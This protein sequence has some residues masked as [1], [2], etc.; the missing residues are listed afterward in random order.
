MITSFVYA[1]S[2]SI[3]LALL[4]G[5]IGTLVYPQWQFWPPPSTQSWQHTTFRRLF[6]VFVAGLVV[7]SVMA[8]SAT[9]SAWRFVIG[10]ALLIVG[11][12]LA[13]RWTSFLGWKN[14]FGDAQGLKTEGIYRW[15]RHPIYVVS[16]VGMLGWGI[17]I[18]SWRVTSLLVIWAAFYLVAP[19]LEEPWLERRYGA[20]FVDYQSCVPRFFW[21]F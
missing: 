14:A 11:F 4:G 2:L 1:V 21:R 17:A 3:G 16:I 9:T 6:R 18:D 15:S 7:L 10:L 19:F 5:S 12:G 20:A 13:F 8:F